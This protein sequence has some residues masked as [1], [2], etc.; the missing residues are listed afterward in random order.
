MYGEE[1]KQRQ[2]KGRPK[3]YAVAQKAADQG[4]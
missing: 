1:A 4:E 3:E 2:G